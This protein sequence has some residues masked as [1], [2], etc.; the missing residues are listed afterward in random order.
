MAPASQPG[1]NAVF[2][3]YWLPVLIWMAMIFKASSDTQSYVHSSR[4]FEPLLHWLFPR[5][6]NATVEELHHLFR[7]MCHLTEYAILAALLWRAIRK[8]AWRDPAAWNWGQAGWALLVVFA[9]AGSDEF[10]QLF[11][12]GRTSLFSDVLIDTAGGAA[13]LLVLWAGQKIVS[14]R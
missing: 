4:L 2:L 10:H 14:R 5:L 13:G 9:Y 3:R 12:P 8:P 6:S 7:K 1:R 11:V